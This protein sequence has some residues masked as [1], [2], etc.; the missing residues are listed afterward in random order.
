[1]PP[2]IEA[3]FEAA[4]KPNSL[5]AVKAWAKQWVTPC[6]QLVKVGKEDPDLK[7]KLAVAYHI[8]IRNIA[9]TAADHSVVAVYQSGPGEHTIEFLMLRNVSALA[10][11]PTQAPGIA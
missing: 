2:A 8:L 11:A 1:M 5:E 9:G 3:L 4:A 6:Q 10:T 7:E